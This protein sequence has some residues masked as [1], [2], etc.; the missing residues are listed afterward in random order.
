LPDQELV[1]LV[2][3]M[4]GLSV[5]EQDVYYQNSLSNMRKAEEK[6]ERCAVE[7]ERLIPDNRDLT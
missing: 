6:A 5:Q 7:L 2:E 1:Q 3:T 4:K